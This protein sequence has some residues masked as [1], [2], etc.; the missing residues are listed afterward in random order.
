M[1]APRLHC[2]ERRASQSQ[3]NGRTEHHWHDRLMHNYHSDLDNAES[4][5]SMSYDPQP[6]ID[7]QTLVL[8]SEGYYVAGSSGTILYK[9]ID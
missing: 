5:A 4:H 9:R 6:L 8:L 7:Y 1:E 2:G 3:N